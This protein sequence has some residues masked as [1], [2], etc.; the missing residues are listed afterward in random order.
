M[1]SAPQSKCIILNL[2]TGYN[3]A[4]NRHLT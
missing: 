2:L 4:T 3:I 1:I